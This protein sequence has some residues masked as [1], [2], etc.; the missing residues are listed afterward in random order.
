MKQNGN[1]P[2]KHAHRISKR[3]RRM[4]SRRRAD[5]ALISVLETFEMDF[6]PLHVA[7]TFE[8]KQF[9][10]QFYGPTHDAMRQE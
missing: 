7:T 3:H 5:R 6:Q 9:L 4:Q 8:T 10:P 1:R 2:W